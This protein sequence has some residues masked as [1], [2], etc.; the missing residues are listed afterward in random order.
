MRLL[1]LG[2]A[3]LALSLGACERSPIA[4]QVVTATTEPTQAPAPAPT[5]A[6]AELRAELQAHR[7][8]EIQRLHDYAAAGVFPRNYTSNTP[9]H[10][11]KD[12]DGRRC[13]V[14]NLLHLDGHDDLV[15]ATAR[16]DNGLVVGTLTSGPIYDWVLSSGLT[17]EEVAAIQAPAPRIYD[18][19]DTTVALPGMPLKPIEPVVQEQLQQHFAQVEQMLIANSDQSLDLA[20][21]RLAAAR[22]GA[23]S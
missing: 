12:P 10:M 5:A 17:L 11:F 15:D 7:L 6:Q 21:A 9:L 22:S 1:C 23:A 14:A 19:E 20:T 3:S 8:L 2:S 18:R 16:S 4:T 13:A